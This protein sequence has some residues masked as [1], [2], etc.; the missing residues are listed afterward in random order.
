MLNSELSSKKDKLIQIIKQKITKKHQNC[1][2]IISKAEELKAQFLKT[3]NPINNIKDQQ[4]EEYERKS[5]SL[6]IS[7]QIK[8]YSDKLDKIKESTPTKLLLK[9]MQ[10]YNS[11]FKLK[12]LLPKYKERTDIFIAKNI[13]KDKIQTAQLLDAIKAF[14]SNISVESFEIVLRKL[15]SA[16]FLQ[17][18]K[19]K[20][21]QN[22]EGSIYASD[23]VLYGSNHIIRYWKT[24]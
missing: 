14:E 2:V 12:A 4:Y 11:F 22:F 18:C 5:S 21:K 19:P 24:I 15:Y 17:N 13:N 10:L 6:Y 16:K 20:H 1:S 7:S 9:T 8:K 23:R 3:Y